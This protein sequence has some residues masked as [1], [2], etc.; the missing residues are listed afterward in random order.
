M[1]MVGFS[2]VGLRSR[3]RAPLGAALA[4]ALALASWSAPSRAAEPQPTLFEELGVDLNML[5]QNLEDRAP[6]W[7]DVTMD[8]QPEAVWIGRQS[9]EYLALPEGGEPE[10]RPVTIDAKQLGQGPRATQNILPLDFDD[11][12][13]QD[14]FLTGAHALLFRQVS[15]EVL[16]VHKFPMPS[17]PDVTFFDIAVADFNSDGL[18]DICLLYTSDAADE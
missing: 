6:A 9:M 12:G 3:A 4:L 16:K 14:L 11:D 2:E 18:P 1:S 5:G 15:P 13:V 8:G 7:V 17:I 10:L